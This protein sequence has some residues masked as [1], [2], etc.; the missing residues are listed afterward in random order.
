MS[1]DESLE[2]LPTTYLHI[3]YIEITRE[4]AMNRRNANTLEDRDRSSTIG[5]GNG[6]T[7]RGERRENEEGRS[8][9]D[10]LPPLYRLSESHSPMGIVH[11]AEWG[12]TYMLH[13]SLLLMNNE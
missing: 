12:G 9:R 1:G 7:R 3:H 10:C 5:R 11:L 13:N 2:R 8:Q 6:L 4:K